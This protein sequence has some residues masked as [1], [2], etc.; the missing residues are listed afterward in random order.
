MLDR[1]VEG[2]FHGAVEDGTHGLVPAGAGMV[3]LRRK[4][5]GE[6][7]LVPCLPDADPRKRRSRCERIR[8]GAVIPGG[9]GSG[10][11]REVVSVRLPGAGDRAL[12]LVQSLGPARRTLDR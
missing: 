10:E 8:E 12:W 5:V 11:L 9:D 1:G 6:V 2:V 7:R 3:P 4:V